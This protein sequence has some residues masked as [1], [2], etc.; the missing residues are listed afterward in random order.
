MRSVDSEVFTWRGNSMSLIDCYWLRFV[1]TH[2]CGHVVYVFPTWPI[3]MSTGFHTCNPFRAHDML[4]G[5]WLLARYGAADSDWS[6][7]GF[8]TMTHYQSWLA[9]RESMSH[10]E[11]GFSEEP[12]YMSTLGAG[13]L[14]SSHNHIS[15]FIDY[16]FNTEILIYH[17]FGNQDTT[18]FY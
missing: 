9:W 3:V 1:M 16:T 4:Y 8:H 11:S 2:V 14:G 13:D 12:L 6:P 5:F 17:A 15:S 10:T 18:V 7:D